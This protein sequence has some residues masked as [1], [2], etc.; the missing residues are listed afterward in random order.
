MYVAMG[1]EG[2]KDFVGGESI[3]VFAFPVLSGI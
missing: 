2:L 1:G 3:K